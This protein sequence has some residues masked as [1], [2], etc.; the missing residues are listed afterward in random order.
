MNWNT[1]T[2]V[3][4][5]TLL[6]ALAVV[7]LTAGCAAGRITKGEVQAIEIECLSVPACMVAKTIALSEQKQYESEAKLAEYVE[8]YDAMLQWCNAHQGYIAWITWPCKSQ[9]F[10]RCPPTH[11]MQRFGCS[12]TNTLLY[13]LGIGGRRF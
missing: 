2:A 6:L 4:S 13:E 3:V 7:I 12:D 11:L 8:S 5:A 1:R 9:S 10:G